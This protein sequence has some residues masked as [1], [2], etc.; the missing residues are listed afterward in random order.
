MLFPRAVAEELNIASMEIG[1]T[2]VNI[3]RK[4]DLLATAGYET[5]AWLAD[6]PP[7]L[8]AYS[9][10]RRFMAKRRWVPLELVQEWRPLLGTTWAELKVNGNIK[11]WQEWDM[12]P[13]PPA[14][15]TPRF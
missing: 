5:T 7:H 12:T 4:V 6:I 8:S 14:P 13:T 11:E 1:S 10:A 3:A 2:N 9:V 15:P